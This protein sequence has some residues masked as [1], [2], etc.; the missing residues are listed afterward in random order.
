MRQRIF[1]VLCWLTAAMLAGA[2]LTL[3]W[4]NTEA[5]VLGTNFTLNLSIDSSGYYSVSSVEKVPAAMQFT[6]TG[7]TAFP[8]LFGK[9]FSL[10]FSSVNGQNFE[11]HGT[12]GGFRIGMTGG[13][14]RWRFDDPAKVARITANL[15][16]I[17]SSQAFRIKSASFLNTQSESVIGLRD[18]SGT[19]QQTGTNPGSNFTADLSG[20]API[21]TGG[22]IGYFE[23]R[24]AEGSAGGWGRLVFEFLSDQEISGTPIQPATIFS[25]GCVLQRDRIV[26]I[27]GTCAPEETI[28]V[29][30]KDQV[31]TVVAGENGT[32]RVELDPE[33]A[34]GPFTMTIS[35][36]NSAPAVLTTVYFGDVWILTG[37]SNMFQ[38]LA[39]QVRNFPNDYPPVPDATDN[40]DDMRLAI[41]SRVSAEEP[42][43][44]AV[45]DL[46]WRRWESASLGSMSAAGYFFA[47]KL[48]A[49]LEENG[50]GDIPLGLIKVCRGGTSIEEWI[51][52]EDLAAAKAQNP[53]LILIAAAS[54][55]YN[56]MIAPIQDYA[57]KGAL[58]YQGE[59]NA[60]SI[61]RISQY[62]LLKQTLAESW[63]RQWK[64]PDLPLYFV[65]LAPYRRYSTVPSDQLWPWMRESQE[66][67]LAV[68][69]TGMACIIDSGLQGDIHP[70]FK[71][72]VGERLARI[73]LAQTYGIPVV[74]RGP[75]VRDVQMNGSEVTI[76]FDH[77]AAGLETRAVDS[78]PD[79]DEVAAGFPAVSVSADTLAGFALC[80]A[81]RVFYWATQAQVISSNQVRISNATDVPNPVAVRYAW[82]D[83]PRC[84]LFNSEALPAE[85]FR[86][87]EF[88]FGTSTGADSTPRSDAG[89]GLFI[90]VQAVSL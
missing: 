45:M 34:G 43:A 75:V 41:V 28:T 53:A 79:A 59:G 29:A 51:S 55:F 78:Q 56:G 50:M 44:D 47:G 61:D 74:S 62:P 26:A 21:L 42:A 82:Q 54:G 65:Q 33:P 76:T 35:G 72:R 40:F 64:N 27:W 71:D 12:T 8:D 90:R 18:A 80:G 85:P 70:P 16:A 13:A 48:K 57:V 37:Q 24:A 11:S 36:A 49:V 4:S 17:S 25:S 9:S 1:I 10:N 46:A 7:S 63:R 32:W 5:T 73:A 20:I 69:N 81:D 83:Y 23:F 2:S 19:E 58:W 38:T 22:S 39:G 6:A 68:T 31:K 14:N 86:T 87:D 60:S 89:T 52:A 3:N 88:E 84:N 30:I 15:T 77:V 67:C 66:R